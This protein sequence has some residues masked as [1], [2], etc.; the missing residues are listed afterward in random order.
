M[1]EN[2]KLLTLEEAAERCR[3]T[4]ETIREWINSGKL[5]GV[6]LAGWSIRID[7]EDL[8]KFIEESKTNVRTTS[9]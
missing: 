8:E 2:K 7:E 3:V 4:P 9:N 1:K 5:R 6:K